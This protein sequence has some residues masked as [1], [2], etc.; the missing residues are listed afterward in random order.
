M[1]HIASNSFLAPCEVIDR[2]SSRASSIRDLLNPASSAETSGSQDAVQQGTQETTGRSTPP[3]SLD[4]PPK[5]IDRQATPEKAEVQG[6]VSV[7]KATPGSSEHG[8][9]RKRDL[10][11]MLG[12]KAAG[13]DTLA[14]ADNG[15]PVPALA[16]VKEPLKRSSSMVR[17]S[18]TVD[19]AMKIRTNNEPTPSPEK[20]RA[21]PPAS[22]QNKVKTPLARSKSAMSSVEVFPDSGKKAQSRPM[23]AGFGRSRDSRT[24]EFFCDSNAKDALSTQAEAETAGS[25]VSAINLIRTNSFKGRSQALSPSLSSKANSQ[26]TPPSKGGKPKFARAKSSL[27]RLQGSGGSA[28]PFRGKPNRPGH[29]HSGSD[30]SDKENW[31]P[32]TRMSEHPLRRTQPTGRHRPI[33]Q[34]NEDMTFPDAS[35]SQKLRDGKA[36]TQASPTKKAKGEE[37][38]CVQ[39]LLS[40]SQ[41]AWR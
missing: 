9:A 40:L 38:D 41:G 1:S 7:E 23:G 12:E 26:L 4:E 20:P 22:L 28:E 19:G 35:S 15:A 32:G 14:Q 10:D 29:G 30:D 25:A 8:S 13:P 6:L 27:A 11:E 37:L 17:L 24:W 31:A 36:D 5:T 34:E 3:S 33:L 21:P 18:M 2:P 16:Q 39:G